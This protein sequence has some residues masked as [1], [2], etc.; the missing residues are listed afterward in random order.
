MALTVPAVPTGMKTGVCKSPWAVWRTP[1]RAAPSVALHSNV[2][3]MSGCMARVTARAPGATHIGFRHS[4]TDCPPDT[5]APFRARGAIAINVK[6]A[7]PRPVRGR[8]G[9]EC[10]T[11]GGR[12]WRQALVMACHDRCFAQVGTG[13]HRASTIPRT[14]SAYRIVSRSRQ[15]YP[16]YRERA[17]ERSLVTHNVSQAPHA[18]VTFGAE[19]IGSGASRQRREQYFTLSQS[20]THFLR[21]AKGRPQQAQRLVGK[22]SLRRIRGMALPGHWLAA[23]VE[24]AAVR[25][26]GQAVDDREQMARCL[27]GSMDLEARRGERG[28]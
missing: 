9:G 10:R 16:A 25:F 20:R 27:R 15:P 17:G 4:R 11:R 5:L 28:G 12:L 24:K 8:E 7:C 2:R 19:A 14:L 26:S 23:P 18:L 6:K 13:V 3:V 21:H 22:S 1:A